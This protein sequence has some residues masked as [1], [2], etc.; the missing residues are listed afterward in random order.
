LAGGG[1]V[2]EEGD[3]FEDAGFGEAIDVAD[4]RHSRFSEYGRRNLPAHAP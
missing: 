3:A 1:G 2:L 4:R